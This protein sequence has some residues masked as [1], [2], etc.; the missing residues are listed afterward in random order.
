MGLG[1]IHK[2]TG[3]SLLKCTCS[4]NSTNDKFVCVCRLA[5]WNQGPRQN[6][7]R[8]TNHV[9][10]PSQLWQVMTSTPHPAQRRTVTLKTRKRKVTKT[11]VWTWRLARVL[12]RAQW[13]DWPWLPSREVCSCWMCLVSARCCWTERK[14]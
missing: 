13:D 5:A 11:V 2:I 4:I 12:Q 6:H 7:H 10:S 8:P 3:C 1:I 9:V 14:C